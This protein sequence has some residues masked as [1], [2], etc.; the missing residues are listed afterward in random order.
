MSIFEMITLLL[1]SSVVAAIVGYFSTQHQSI[2]S[3]KVKYITEERQK[4]RH[5]IK[6]GVAKFCSTDDLEEKRR[7][8]TFI[9]LSLNPCDSQDNKIVE[10][11]NKLTEVESKKEMAE[12]ERMVAFLL[13]HDW[14]RA[15][16][17]VGIWSKI[18]NRNSEECTEPTIERD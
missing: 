13:K 5:D 18:V 3:H 2:R 10:A 11:L 14:E 8:K 6:N 4:W 17:E 1:G 16:E 12:L 9:T 7:L 15:K